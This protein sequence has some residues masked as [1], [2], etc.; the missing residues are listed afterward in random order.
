MR[1]VKGRP[2]SDW[3]SRTVIME[4]ERGVALDIY[5]GYLVIYF[6]KG[7][8]IYPAKP[9]QLD[10]TDWQKNPMSAKWMKERRKEFASQIK[11]AKKEVDEEENE[12]K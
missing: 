10:R 2:L 6:M 9:A 1:E 4:G 8:Y 3:I 11:N 12:K 5:K 7:N